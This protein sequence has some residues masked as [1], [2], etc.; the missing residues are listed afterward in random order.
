M[1]LIWGIDGIEDECLVCFQIQGRLAHDTNFGDLVI[2]ETQVA[3]TN[4]AKPAN[5]LGYSQ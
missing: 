2:R 4:L 5:R 1:S 3:R